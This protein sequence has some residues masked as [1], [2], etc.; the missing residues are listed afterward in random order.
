MRDVVVSTTPLGI[1]DGSPRFVSDEALAT[2]DLA[3]E[4]VSVSNECWH[5]MNAYTATKLKDEDACGIAL[6]LTKD[7]WANST[8]LAIHG[9]I[10]DFSIQI[11][12]C[13]SWARSS[14]N[15]ALLSW[16]RGSALAIWWYWVGVVVSS[17]EHGCDLSAREARNQDGHV[18]CLAD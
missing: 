18:P 16:P 7:I 14:N 17:S 6:A 10:D 3:M 2:D 8:V 15:P 5:Q 1:R 13:G 11:R 9:Q 12:N 4:T